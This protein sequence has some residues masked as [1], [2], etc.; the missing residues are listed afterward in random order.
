MLG[1][2]AI[3]IA[4]LSYGII[5]LFQNITIALIEI[6]IGTMVFSIVIAIVGIGYQ[7]VAGLIPAIIGKLSALY[8]YGLQILK[9]YFFGTSSIT[10][11][12]IK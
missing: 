12:A 3:A 9:A 6:G 4:G 5:M 7:L 8:K 1:P 10:K 11:A 2:T